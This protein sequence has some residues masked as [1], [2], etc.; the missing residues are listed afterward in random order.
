MRDDNDVWH[1]IDADILSKP[2]EM[3]GLNGIDGLSSKEI[4][5]AGLNGEIWRF[6]GAR[7]FPVPSPTNVMLNSVRCIGEHVYIAGNAGLLLRG[8]MGSF[9]VVATQSDEP[10]LDAVEG[11][12]DAVY[13]ASQKKLFRL[14]GK[15]LREVDTKLGEITAGSLSSRDG[16]MWS[17][18]A[19]H[20]I[21]TDDGKKWTQVF[22]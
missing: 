3:V 10:N 5:A 2:G 19:K 1:H 16:V 9:Q 20:L 6:T 11:F 18:G 8:R 4:Y 14:N 13:V 12:G 15:S 21:W 17:V 22:V 7:W